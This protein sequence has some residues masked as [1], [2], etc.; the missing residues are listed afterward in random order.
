M[1]NGS[2]FA[3]CC[4]GV[5][6]ISLLLCSLFEKQR[7]H[8][9]PH[10]HPVVAATARQRRW[11]LVTAGSRPA[12]GWCLFARLGNERGRR[13]YL[14]RYRL[15]GWRLRVRLR[16]RLSST[17]LLEPG[18]CVPPVAWTHH[19]LPMCLLL[20]PLQPSPSPHRAAILCWLRAWSK[21][22]ATRCLHARS[23]AAALL[24]RGRSLR[25]PTVA[26][27]ICGGGLPRSHHGPAS[28]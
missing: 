6:S 7:G 13:H 25:P 22:R 19:W 21:R 1:R 24:S 2:Y 3:G 16:R 28:P 8:R 23:L 12:C 10:P 14:R 18:R 4:T 5:V 27:A 9:A 17:A 11:R 15:R 20:L 26:S